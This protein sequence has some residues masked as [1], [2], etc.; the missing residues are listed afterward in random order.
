MGASQDTTSETLK[1]SETLS[2][3]Y[4]IEKIREALIEKR[5]HNCANIINERKRRLCELYT[6]AKV[7]LVAISSEHVLQSEG[8]LKRFLEKNDLQ[9]GVEFTITALRREH[10]EPPRK[11]MKKLKKASHTKTPNPNLLS[12]QDNTNTTHIDKALDK[13][14]S[15][16]EDTTKIDVQTIKN[17]KKEEALKAMKV[18]LQKR[19]ELLRKN[20]KKTVGEENTEHGPTLLDQIQRFKKNPT[21]TNTELHSNRDLDW[22]QMKLDDLLLT[23]MPARKPHKVAAARSLTELYYHEQTLQLPKLLLRAH[24]V[25]TSKSFETS[26]VEGKVAVLFSRIEELKKRDRW[27]L[28]QPRKHADPFLHNGGMTFWDSLLSEAQWVATDMKQSRRYRAAKCCEI[29]GEVDEYWKMQNKSKTIAGNKIDKHQ[30]SGSKFVQDD[31]IK[32]SDEK[33]MKEDSSLGNHLDIAKSEDKDAVS[34]NR[35]SD[36]NKR[37]IMKNMAST[38]SK[39]A[40]C[41]DPLKTVIHSS[42]IEIPVKLFQNPAKLSLEII[43]KDLPTAGRVILDKLPVYKPF[44]S[45]EQK[46]HE[47]RVDHAIDRNLFGHVSKLLPPPSGNDEIC[48]EKIVFRKQSDQHINLKNGKNNTNRP[49]FGRFSHYNVLRPPRPPSVA[50]IQLRIPTIWLPQDDRLLVR[51]V[52]QFSFNWDIIAAHLAPRPTACR[53]FSNIERRTPWQCFERYIQLNNRFRFS[54]MRGKYTIEARKWLQAAHRVQATTRRRISPLGVGQDSIQRG[55]RRLRWASMLEAFRKLMRRREAAANVAKASNARNAKLSTENS[56]LKKSESGSADAAASDSNGNEKSRSDTPTPEQLSKLKSERD[57]AIKRA[58]LAA[59]T[60]RSHHKD[61]NSNSDAR[62]GRSQ[63]HMQ[64]QVQNQ[65]LMQMQLRLRRQEQIRRLQK[66]RQ[67]QHARRAQRQQQQQQQLR[68][69]QWQMQMQQQQQNHGK[70]SNN[71]ELATMSSPTSRSLSSTLSQSPSRRSPTPTPEQ[72]LAAGRD[73][74]HSLSSSDLTSPASTSPS[75][76]RGFSAAQVA[77]VVNQIQVRNPGI[78]RSQATRLAVLYMSNYQKR[79]RRLRQGRL[80]RQQQTQQETMPQL[81]SQIQNSSPAAVSPALSPQASS[82]SP[83]IMN[84][85]RLNSVEQHQQIHVHKHTPS[86]EEIQE[87]MSQHRASRQELSVD[88]SMSGIGTPVLSSPPSLHASSASS[89]IPNT[90]QIMGQ[91]T[92]TTN[93]NMPRNITDNDPNLSLEAIENDILN[94]DFSLLDDDGLNPN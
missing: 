87:A 90:G 47:Q 39:Q 89:P 15:E 50:D 26:L 24:K 16:K 58:Y 11:K 36:D 94:T 45:G 5:K 72:I 62:C 51:Y 35:S 2:S 86:P 33:V 91:G 42:K 60:G 34:G 59:N 46:D 4:S 74:T 19:I 44:P 56:S 79:H 18:S 25:L 9:K 82:L 13:K 78:S 69:Q 54:D 71:Q 29:S 1:K 27:S 3:E 93:T 38:I 57:R 32:S 31:N 30:S 88:Q 6:V 17:Q 76:Q 8:E 23:L 52:T 37:T 68:R 92:S 22:Q 49:L 67:I 77:A 14:V 83:K 80:L 61:N 10:A 41:I 64:V 84:S 28:R 85:A 55:H 40:A 81:Q 7:P 20:K 66:I 48:W 53:Y 75:H 12:G 70:I 63:L 65:R 21:L 43:V 73:H